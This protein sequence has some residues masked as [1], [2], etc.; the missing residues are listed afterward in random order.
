M[1]RVLIV[2]D[3]AAVRFGVDALLS[4]TGDLEVVGLCVD[5][6]DAVATAAAARPDVAVMDVSMP[7]MDGITATGRLRAEVPS[8][9]VLIL[10]MSASDQLVQDAQRAGASGYLLKSAP[11][12][13]LVAAVRELAAGRTAWSKWAQAALRRCPG[14]APLD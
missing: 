7:G 2:D 3:N 1:T 9:R 10:T 11:H 4:S 14:A 8:C 5:G 12:D 13:E 6:A